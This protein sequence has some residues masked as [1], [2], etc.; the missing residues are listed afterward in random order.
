[1]R[2]FEFDKPVD[3]AKMDPASFAQAIQTGQETGVL[4][5]FEFEVCVP[6]ETITSY[7]KT[8]DVDISKKQVL[9]QLR[10]NNLFFEMHG[11]IDNTYDC[12][13]K[14]FDDMFKFVS[15][16]SKYSSMAEVQKVLTANALEKVK[17]LFVTVPENKRRLLKIGRAH[18]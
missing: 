9:E 5:G 1:M 10:S 8:D 16:T 3:E 14:A 4:V 17:A 13:V 12:S 11:D 2:I 7:S 6:E 15:G 18:V